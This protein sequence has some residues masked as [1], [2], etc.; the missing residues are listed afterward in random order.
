MTPIPRAARARLLTLPI[1]LAISVLF[2]FPLSAQFTKDQPG[3]DGWLVQLE[4]APLA[5]HLKHAPARNKKAA[6]DQRAHL[7]GIRQQVLGNLKQ[8]DVA[9]VEKQRYETLIHAVAIEADAATAARI[10]DLPGVIAVSPN[11]RRH[12]RPTAITRMAAPAQQTKETPDTNRGE[13]RVI[14]IIDTGVDYSHPDLGG[15]FGPEFKVIGGYDFVDNDSDPMDGHWH[16][17]HVA[18]IAAGDGQVKGIAPKA[19]LLAY[20]VLGPFGGLDTDIIAALERAA[21]PDQNPLTDDAADVVN[22]SLGGP[23]HADDI[24]SKAVDAA[25]E[26]G[27]VVVVAAGNN[28]NQRYRVDSPGSAR[29]AVTVAALDQAG[30]VA[31]YSSFGPGRPQIAK[32][33]LAA[34]GTLTSTMPGNQYG[35]AS[36]TSMASPAVAGAAA[37]ILQRFPDFTP[38][39]VKQRLMTTSEPVG[40]APFYAAGSGALRLDAVLNNRLQV[41]STRTYL[42]RINQKTASWQQGVSLRIT[43]HAEEAHTVTLSPRAQRPLGVSVTATLSE[44]TLRLGPGETETVTATITVDNRRGEYSRKHGWFFQLPIQVSTDGQNQRVALFAD[45]YLKV[46]L[47]PKDN[48]SIILHA[49]T[50][51]EDLSPDE[52]FF[53]SQ[54]LFAE[55]GPQ[56]I[57]VHA[58]AF[59]GQNATRDYVWYKEIEVENDTRITF[60]P[61]DCTNTWSPRF[62]G[63]D[64]REQTF[65]HQNLLVHHLAYPRPRGGALHDTNNKFPQE[66]RTTDL[67]AYLD[68]TAMALVDLGANRVAL[69]G[70]PLRNF[71]DEPSP[72]FDVRDF[73]KIPVDLD[74]AAA[75]DASSLYLEVNSDRGHWFFGNRIIQPIPDPEGDPREHH[76]KGRQNL[77]LYVPADWSSLLPRRKG[78]EAQHLGFW[79]STESVRNGVSG[80][81]ITPIYQVTEKGTLLAHRRRGPEDVWPLTE[82]TPRTRINLNGGNPIPHL[83]LAFD[84]DRLRLVLDSL[85]FADMAVN[86]DGIGAGAAFQ[87]TVIRDDR[88]LVDQENLWAVLE[89][90]TDW[91]PGDYEI[92]LTIGGASARYRARYDGETRHHAASPV[93]G[94][95]AYSDGRLTLDF[96]DRATHQPD[97]PDFTF[98]E[99]NLV[100]AVAARRGGE[101]DWQPLDITRDPNQVGR[102]HCQPPVPALDQRIDL[103]VTALDPRTGG[104]TELIVPGY[105]HRGHATLIPWVVNNERFQNQ[106]AFF[107]GTDQT[108]TV[109]LTAAAD[110]GETRRRTIILPAHSLQTPSPQHLFPG[111]DRYSLRMV[112]EDIN[113]RCAFTTRNH[114]AAPAQTTGLPENQWSPELTFGYLARD[115][116]P[117]LVLTAPAQTGTTPDDERVDLVLSGAGGEIGRHSLTLTEGRPGAFTL[118]QFF[119]ADRFETTMHLRATTESGA[120]LA[121]T[122]FSFNEQRAPAMAT[123][124]SWRTGVATEQLI[125]WVVANDRWVSEIT[126]V[127]RGPR[128]A[129]AVF[130]AYPSEDTAPITITRPIERGLTVLHAADLFPF[131][132]GYT[133]TLQGLHGDLDVTY[134]TLATNNRGLPSPSMTTAVKDEERGPI[135]DFALVPRHGFS[136]MVVTAPRAETESEVLV[137]VFRGDGGRLETTRTLSVGRPLVLPL[138]DFLP[139]G[140]EDETVA[141]RVQSRADLPLA[142]TV[143]H[144]NEAGEAS[145]SKAARFH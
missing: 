5:R 45:K 16:G 67:P 62:I 106:L 37:A 81:S 60:D 55:P 126:L 2:C 99:T 41:E 89:R 85:R 125:P 31:G 74:L 92:H 145:M 8:A 11:Q 86:S 49:G 48:Q 22:L 104:E 70:A 120:P 95:A 33:D 12:V 35:E 30:A 59:V 88:V 47:V 9:F 40:D 39:Q 26:I 111:L 53:G 107:N 21:D 20:R 38:E 105:L 25:V 28:G 42:G 94:R 143:F 27:M 79:L 83:G 46:D 6:L 13:G 93:V 23:G 130:T 32:P 122:V 50:I 98:D 52:D 71:G 44:T 58:S 91:G 139:L 118:A 7:A 135:L 112:A 129:K 76:L 18:G 34:L 113:V 101:T 128:M 108:Q 102:Y 133:L 4:G 1:I 75:A 65:T 29:L 140:A 61:A 68:L 10:R 96:L 64:G 15:G 14:A 109:Q 77:E 84:P 66:V 43:N 54:D 82:G 137:T 78:N 142:G 136:A 56:S 117:A 132:K 80:G 51:G 123:A 24:L 19:K 138:E 72:V 121:G 57:L 87:I 36:G 115:L 144:F 131:G 141:V 90:A 103:Q 17:T 97:D 116:I 3:A 63:L 100:V 69:M 73:V 119:D 134:T 110:S 114:N 124:L 127:N